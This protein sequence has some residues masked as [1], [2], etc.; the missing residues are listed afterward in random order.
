[1]C[2]RD[3]IIT[4]AEIAMA[5]YLHNNYV[6]LLAGGGIVGFAVFYS[7]YG[8]LIV[9]FIRKRRVAEPMKNL[10]IIIVVLLLVMDV[11]LVSYYSKD[12]Y[13]ILMIPFLEIDKLSKK[14]EA[15]V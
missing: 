5:T 8:Y 2:I 9:N 1:M 10:C 12:L 11:A 4:A 6:E 7:M 15:G 14:E 3:S 13:F